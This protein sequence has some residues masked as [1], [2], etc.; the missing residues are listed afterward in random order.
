MEGKIVKI[1]KRVFP[2][3]TFASLK[4]RKGLFETVGRR[5]RAEASRLKWSLER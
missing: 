5:G 1:E 4:M 3:E 2:K